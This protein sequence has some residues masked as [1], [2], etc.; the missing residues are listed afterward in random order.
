[1]KTMKKIKC[2]SGVV[3]AL[4]LSF[5]SCSDKDHFS[6]ANM[7]GEFTLWENISSDEELSNFASVLEATG[8]AN[9]L[10]SSQVFTVFAPSNEKLSKAECDN[11]IA[12][13]NLEKASG[14]KDD[15]NTVIVEFIQ[16]HIAL[17][18]YTVSEAGDPQSIRMM[19]GKGSWFTTNS[20]AGVN[21]QKK[22]LLSSNGVLYV[23]SDKINYAQ[24]IYEYIKSETGGDEGLD[25]LSNFLYKYHFTEFKADE[26]T[27]GEIVDGKLQYLDSVT[28]VRNEILDDWLRAK[29]DSEDS[30]YYAVLPTNKAWKEQYDVN[31]YFFKYVHNSQSPD[32]VVSSELRDSFEYVLPRYTIIAGAQ[33]SRTTN[34]RLG[35]EKVD[36]VKSPLATKYGYRKLNYGSFDK[37]VFE[38]YSPYEV[39]ADVPSSGI[40]VEPDSV[41]CSNGVAFKAN[42]WKIQRGN[43]FL[44]DISMEAETSASLDSVYYVSAVPLK[45]KPSWI[46]R[47]V[48]SSSPF[49]EEVMGH[50]YCKLQSNTSA[51]A[52]A[53]FN[54]TNVLS[55]LWYD[56]YVVTVPAQ[57]SD[58][59]PGDIYRDT[60]G[61]IHS[62][63]TR[64]QATIYCKT[65]EGL[66][67][68]IEFK[69]AYDPAK[70]YGRG[71]IKIEDFGEISIDTD[72]SRTPPYSYET[73][74]DV[75]HK[76]RIGRIKFPTCT[77]WLPDPMV[78]FRVEINVLSTSVGVTKSRN[79][80]IDRVL[81]SPVIDKSINDIKNNL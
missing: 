13:Y 71:T 4:A 15:K 53:L 41:V 35:I 12:Q 59:D 72:Y 76:V 38:Y 20:L 42:E 28:T 55:N 58:H 49:Y 16:N 5:T 66:Q 19:N 21:F 77:Y 29:L 70:T 24:N 62:L 51:M 74:P 33:F 25:S 47:D 14:V 40:F 1:M 3:V 17:Y 69:T 32:T 81:L 68:S 60:E 36:S 45:I 67:D 52:G 27:P 26:S 80:Y 46:S 18:N 48:K 61:N 56:L 44:Q 7:G 30:S 10:A 2:L 8:Y 23:L 63:P 75:V 39:K 65:P 6:V 57:A 50:K 37:R 73:N 11:L 64:I 79:L 54:F 9:K 43:T 22:N 31:K 78:K 34:P